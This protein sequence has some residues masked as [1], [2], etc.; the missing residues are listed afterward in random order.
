MRVTSLFLWLVVPLIE[1]DQGDTI[2]PTPSADLPTEVQEYP[3]MLANAWRV[4]LD[5]G[6][7]VFTV[8]NINLTPIEAASR[9]LA[10]QKIRDAYNSMNFVEDLRWQLKYAGVRLNA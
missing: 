4:A 9:L 3:A 1:T 2:I 5:S 10:E 7:A 8:R 6:N